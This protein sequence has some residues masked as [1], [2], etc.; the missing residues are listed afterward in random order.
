MYMI[1]WD[2]GKTNTNKKKRLHLEV[3]FLVGDTELESVTSTIG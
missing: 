2:E 3:A 1:D